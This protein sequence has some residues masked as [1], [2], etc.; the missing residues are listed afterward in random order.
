[1][2]LAWSKDP[3]SYTGGSV[4]FGRVSHAGQVKVDGPE[5]KENP[6]PSGWEL[7]VRQT[8]SPRKNVS[9]E[10]NSKMPRMGLTKRRQS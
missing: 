2:G 4:A 3:T 10:K 1:V 5:E 7:G 6:D 9:V 8:T